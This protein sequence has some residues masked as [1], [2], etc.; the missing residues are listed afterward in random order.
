MLLSISATL[1]LCVISSSLPS[2]PAIIISRYP[3]HF[4]IVDVCPRALH[5]NTYSLC[6]APELNVYTIPSLPLVPSI[7]PIFHPFQVIFLNAS[8]RASQSARFLEYT[9]VKCQYISRV[10]IIWPYNV[11]VSINACACDSMQR[12][13]KCRTSLV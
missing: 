8:S 6:Y 10:C 9:F 4:F 1:H 13:N 3:V 12:T 7:T 2:Y 5:K 11:L